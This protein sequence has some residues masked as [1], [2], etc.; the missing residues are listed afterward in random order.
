MIR[1]LAN[2]LRGLLRRPKPRALPRRGAKPPIG[3]YIVR[4]DVRMTIQAGLSDQLWSLLLDEG[5]REPRFQPDRRRYREIPS[6]WVTRLIDAPPDR[7]A[8]VLAAAVQN[9]VQR[10]LPRG[11]AGAGSRLP[12]RRR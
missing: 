1:T 5:W 6:A 2:R 3:A 9:A 11:G 8:R 4:D 12:M 7:S 10:P